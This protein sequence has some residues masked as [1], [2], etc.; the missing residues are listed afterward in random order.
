[1]GWCSA[2]RIFDNVVDT[3]RAHDIKDPAFK[4]ILWNL[5]CELEDMDWDCQCESDYWEDDQV[6]GIFKEMNPKWFEDDE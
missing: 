3:L 2:T 1:M 5:I 6:R 4:N